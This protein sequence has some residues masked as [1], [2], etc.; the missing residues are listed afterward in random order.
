[1][2]RILREGA[3]W[4][5][6]KFAGWGFLLRRGESGFWEY[7]LRR[8]QE[9]SR[10]IDQIGRFA[11]KPMA[12]GMRFPGLTAGQDVPSYAYR[13]RSGRKNRRIRLSGLAMDPFFEKL[14]RLGPA[15]F[16]AEGLVA[17]PRGRLRCCWPST[18]FAGPTAAFL[19]RSEMQASSNSAKKGR[20][21]VRRDPYETWRR[22]KPFRRRIVET[23]ATRALKRRIRRI[24]APA[25]RF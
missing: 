2:Q 5:L 12:A 19:L 7:I 25:V 13:I 6:R 15:A 1:V 14:L 3:E 16:S 22:K 21:G 4:R 24:G 17:G 10:K 11:S 8:R 20:H 18:C 9:I 23:I